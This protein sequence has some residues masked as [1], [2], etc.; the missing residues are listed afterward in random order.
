MKRLFCFNL[1]LALV[2]VLVMGTNQPLTAQ[3]DA[4]FEPGV[5]VSIASLDEHFSDIEH[6][7]EASGNGQF[8]GLVRVFT[9]D[10]VRGIDADKPIGAMIF[11]NEENPEE[12]DFM[13]FV[14]VTDI[15][16]VLDTLAPYVDIEDEDDDYVLTLEG[17]AVTVRVIDGY[18]FVVADTEMLE[19]VPSNPVQM[20][21]DLPTRFNVGARVFGQ[22]IPESLRDQVI[23]VIRSGAEDEMGNFDGPELEMQRANL[24]YLMGQME[25]FVNETEELVIGF[26]VDQDNERLYMDLEMVGLEGSHLARQSEG[27]RD[28]PKTRFGGFINKDATGSFNFCAKMLEEDIKQL[29]DFLEQMERSGKELIE[30]DSDEMSEQEVM[31]ANKILASIFGVLQA[32]AKLGF[33]DAA[34]SGV[35][36]ENELKLVMGMAIQEGAKL[37][38]SLKE[39]AKLAEAEGDDLVEFNFDVSSEGGIRYHQITLMVPAEEE[40]ARQLLGEELEILLGV[41]DDAAYVAMGEGSQA[42]LKQSISGSAP[43]LEEG[44]FM[45]GSFHL[46][47]VMRFF[48]RVQ[49]AEQLADIIDALPETDNDM[50][51]M[52][53]RV[54]EN[55]Q[56]FRF[57]MQDEILQILTAI[58]QQVAGGG[59]APPSD[60]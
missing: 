5:V 60:F 28:S 34:G 55:G 58:G 7:L 59:F 16:D 26:C 19:R 39:V 4:E 44:V 17:T 51:Q 15:E 36:D 48:S 40:E 21:K 52:S 32:S 53:M 49:D 20:L 24:E 27:F 47:P 33:M 35:M 10:Y 50:M 25:A 37:E 12:P 11:F 18:A 45:Q 29:N 22:N 38:E 2:A 9:A 43:Q 42:M 56:N 1:Y 8:A 54:V 23:E 31:S 14:P 13:G 30:R 57:E 3:S 6:V 46:L 41:S